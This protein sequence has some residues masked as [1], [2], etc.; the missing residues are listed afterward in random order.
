MMVIVGMRVSMM[1]VSMMVIVNMRVIMI[2]SAPSASNNKIQLEDDQG[3][4]QWVDLLEPVPKTRVTEDNVTFLLYTRSNPTNPTTLR[5]GVDSSLGEF[6]PKHETVL[7]IHGWTSNPSSVSAITDGFIAT[8]RDYN[9][10]VVDWSG[11][12]S[13]GYVT[14][15]GNAREVG[16]IIATFID[17]LASKGLSTSHIDIIG[18]SLGAQVAGIAGFRVSAGTVGRVTGLDP[19]G[20]LF[21]TASS[22][23]KLD[24][25]DGDFVQV[26][27]TNGGLQGYKGAIGHADF[28]PNGGSRSCAHHRAP[29]F[30]AESLARSTPFTATECGSYRDYSRNECESRPRAVMGA[31]T[32]RRSIFGHPSALLPDPAVS[33]R[34]AGEGEGG[35]IHL[36]EVLD[37]RLRREYVS[38]GVGRRVLDRLPLMYRI[39][40]ALF[41][42]TS[43][44]S[45]FYLP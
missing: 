31:Y 11:P 12:A 10:I 35:L 22:K 25:A 34:G 41:M 6:N 13:P 45:Q 44:P 40:L 27:H 33:A 39:R 2:W 18:F 23:N 21:N 3:N 7:V 38:E 19:A 28:F 43:P 20:P 42:G 36:G 37:D 14:A 29:A 5:T 32:P 4:L 17:Y 8:G 9:V 16:Q 1:I 15:I 30:Y 26:I 24:S